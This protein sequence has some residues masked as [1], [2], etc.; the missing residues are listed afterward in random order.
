MTDKEKLMTVEFLKE[1]FDYVDGVLYWKFRPLH[2]FKNEWSQKIS[3][4]RQAGSRA[5]TVQN[6]YTQIKC[7]FGKVG[8][9]RIIFCMEH[10]FF[11]EEVDH[12]DGNPSNNRIENLRASTHKQNSTNM[13]K[14]SRNTSGVKGVSFHK[15]TGKWMP[16]IRADGKM[17]YLGIYRTIEE[18]LVV[19]KQAE[20]EHYGEFANER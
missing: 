20:K 10:G 1:S 3:N 8:A 6:G 12:I 19:R 4:S 17:K 18:A 13:K 2:H 11:P 16:T 15:T 5:G 7:K 14:P 9:H